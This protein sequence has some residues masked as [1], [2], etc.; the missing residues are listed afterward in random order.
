M[1]L[2]NC[3]V[4]NKYLLNLFGFDSFDDF[5]EKLKDQKE[6]FDNEGK[7]YFIDVIIGFPNLKIPQDV[8][9]KYD[10]A[11]KDYTKRLSANR[12][13]EIRWKYFQYLA[14]LFAEIFL[15]RYFNHKHELLRELNEFLQEFNSKNGVE[16]KEFSLKDLAKLAFWMATGSGKTLI[17]HVN[18]WQFLK[19]LKNRMDNIILIT[20]NEGLSKQ[21]FNEMCWS[22]I[23]CKLYNGN[24]DDLKTSR[25]EVL[26]IDIFKLIEEKKGGGVRVQV[27]YFDGK[28]L[29]FIDEGHKGQR[30]EEKTWKNLRE[31]IG[32]NGFIFEYS[33]TFGQVIGKDQELLEEYSKSIIFDYSYKFFYTDGYGKDFYVFNLREDT[34]TEKYTDLILTANLLSYYEQLIL[35]EKNKERTIEYNI[36]KPLWIFVGS[37]VSGKGIDSDVIRIVKFLKKVLENEKFLQEN[38]QK[39][40]SGNSGL[41]NP[42]GE[43]LFKDKFGY[44]RE[45]EWNI[46][47]LYNQIF[48]GSGTLSVY[49]IKTA[50]GEFGL[51]TTGEYFGVIN[52]GDIS[53]VK[54][55]LTQIGLEVK[56]D[57]FAVSLFFSID[58]EDSHINLLIG[59]KKFIEG[60]NSWRVSSTCLLNMGKG[61][62]P[63]IIQLFGRGVRLKGKNFSLKREEQ[64]DYTTNTLQT[65][66]I[67]GLNANYMNAFLETIKREEVEYEEKRIPIRLNNISEWENKIYTIKTDEKFDFTEIPLKLEINE[68]ILHGLSVDIRPRILTAHGLETG[69]AETA[70]DTPISISPELLE[71]IDWEQIYLELM[72][73]KLNQNFYNLQIPKNVL[74]EIVATRKY[75]LFAAPEQVSLNNFQDTQKIADII[76]TI[77]RAYINRFYRFHEKQETM[78]HLRIEHLKKDDDNLNFNEITLKIPHEKMEEFEEILKDLEE[79]YKK[80]IEYIPT[81]HFDKHLYTPLIIYKK[82]KENIKTSPVKLNKGET[83]FVLNLRDYLLK[84][85]QTL[86]N[87][88]IFLLRNLS[89]RGVGFFITSGFYPDFILW[90]NERDRQRIKFIDPKGLRNLGNFQDEKIQFCT[91]LLKDI[92]K[93][94][95]KKVKNVELEAFILSTSRYEDVKKTFGTGNH[96]KDEFEQNHVLFM[97]D[98]VYIEKLLHTRTEA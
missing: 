89:K 64:P 6:G 32:R 73:Y 37:K 43:D 97:E 11:I 18:Y 70:Y 17:M 63:Q 31:Q 21:H 44:L 29:V 65:L 49:E 95:K 68:D 76:L 69:A 19:Y 56:E 62:G 50:E 66:S 57:R 84:N 54:K 22:G 60:W 74:K 42:K 26:I 30:T 41:L 27:D 46:K 8:L 28:N 7:S 47:D 91:T 90:I 67:F 45:N 12:R 38:I 58:R 35:Y 25:N 24:I 33:A 81:V 48:N 87:K 77:L 15:D 72:N 86:Q 55:L 2:E 98:P 80:D 39:I 53:S 20:P 83:E 23:P 4:L 78:K 9:L 16:I 88:E 71:C 1:K 75:K 59:S 94:I 92:E 52:V 14:I 82:G 13:Q 34:F 51:K 3:L 5:R 93:E 79:I 61:E 85:K 36:E 96:S 10:A 40:L